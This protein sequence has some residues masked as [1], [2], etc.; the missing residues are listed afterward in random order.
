MI[1][2]K[3]NSANTRNAP[4][5]AMFVHQTISHII[6][7]LSNVAALTISSTILLTMG[8]KSL[9]TSKCLG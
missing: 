6:S 2:F 9:M 5:N 8:A 4:E 7:T 1:H 3:S